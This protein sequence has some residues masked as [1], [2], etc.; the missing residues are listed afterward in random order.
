MLI[1]RRARGET[2]Q[3]QQDEL[4]TDLARRV[5]AHA[6]SPEE[7]L[8][9]LLAEHRREIE[10]QAARFEEAMKDLERREEL[11]RDMRASVERLLR[12]G[13]S[14]LTEREVEL[15]EVRLYRKTLGPE[16][17]RFLYA[18]GQLAG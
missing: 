4:S 2:T 9:Q 5:L 16:E 17:I 10:E 8:E 6:A 15:Q 1:P 13:T 11:L 3:G 7:K 14:D 12:L 18:L